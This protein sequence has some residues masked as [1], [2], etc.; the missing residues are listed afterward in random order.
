MVEVMGQAFSSITQQALEASGVGT[1]SSSFDF[2][3]LSTNFYR[4]LSLSDQDLSS[5]NWIR[6][7]ACV[8]EDLLQCYG[9]AF[10]I[11]YLSDPTNSSRAG[12]RLPKLWARFKLQEGLDD[13][14]VYEGGLTMAYASLQSVVWRKFCRKMECASEDSWEVAKQTVERRMAEYKV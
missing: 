14:E 10:A 4:P 11:A 13:L 12:T 2:F 6:E 1:S 8:F 7:M 5:P 9:P 3:Q